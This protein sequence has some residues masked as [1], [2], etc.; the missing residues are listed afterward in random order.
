MYLTVCSADCASELWR[1]WL[2]QRAYCG[3]QIDAGCKNHKSCRILSASN[4]IQSLDDLPTYWLTSLKSLKSELLSVYVERETPC[5]FIN[6]NR[7][8]LCSHSHP[9]HNCP[10]NA[11]TAVRLCIDLRQPNTHNPDIKQLLLLQY[12]SLTAER[13]SGKLD[14]SVHIYWKIVPLLGVGMFSLPYIE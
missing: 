7:C 14:R 12:L 6:I 8:R 10:H 5:L 2:S 1:Q 9:C 13:I 11:T 4:S 3:L